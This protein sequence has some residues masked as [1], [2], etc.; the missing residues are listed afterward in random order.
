MADGQ[1]ALGR[2]AWIQEEPPL[3]CGSQPQTTPLTG[4][5]EGQLQALGAVEV[6]GGADDAGRGL[7]LSPQRE[8]AGEQ[9]ATALRVHEL[10]LCLVHCHVA[11]GQLEGHRGLRVGFH[12]A[13]ALHGVSGRCTVGLQ[14]DHGSNCRG[15][16]GRSGWRQSEARAPWLRAQSRIAVIEVSCAFSFT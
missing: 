1:S 6:A 9:E 11:R 10:P 13:Q 4:S 15:K 16:I 3:P 2:G 7:G 5:L 12:H 14:K 8:N